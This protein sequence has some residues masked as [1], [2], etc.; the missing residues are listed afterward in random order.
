MSRPIPRAIL[1]RQLDEAM[2]NDNKRRISSIMKQLQNLNQPQRNPRVG[3]PIKIPRGR[4]TPSPL[5][6]GTIPMPMPPRRRR[7]PTPMPI[8]TRTTPRRKP[9]TPKSLR[10]I[11]KDFQKRFRV[12]QD[13]KTR[14]QS[15][16]ISEAQR[17]ALMT[18]EPR[19]PRQELPE[20]AKSAIKAIRERQ[21]QQTT[22]RR[23]TKRQQEAQ[24]FS[25]RRDARMKNIRDRMMKRGRSQ[26]DIQRR[27]FNV[28][29][30]F[31]RRGFNK[32]GNPQERAA[33]D[34]QQ[35]RSRE[36]F[37]LVQRGGTQREQ[38]ELQKK[39]QD[40][41]KKGAAPK[42]RTTVQRQPGIVRSSKGTLVKKNSRGVNDFR[43]GGLTLSVTDNKKKKK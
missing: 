16:K 18:R 23:L 11:V 4:R 37:D 3:T 35:K 31:Q 5:T 28:D 32:F 34:L 6:T 26:K 20:Y 14:G 38:F 15:P 33:F 19:Q 13:A 43:K 30:A 10:D 29:M 40:L 42:K 41:M 9:Q 25:Q 36:M 1:L 27:L 8:P 21:R 2:R 7:R 24:R 22:P 17:R 12:A 39:Y